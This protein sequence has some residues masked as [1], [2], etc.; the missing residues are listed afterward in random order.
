MTT[1]NKTALSA[2]I[3]ANKY[4]TLRETYE[5]TAKLLAGENIAVVFCRNLP[6]PALF[7][8]EKRI[9]KINYLAD[10]QIHLT[11]GLVAHEVG[12]ALFTNPTKEDMKQL[13]KRGFS[14]L[15]N[16]VEDGYQ[17]RKMCKAFPGSRKHLKTVFNHFFDDDPKA[18]KPSGK[19]IIDI[20]NVLNW[21]CKGVKHGSIKQ[22]PDYVI[23]DDVMLLFEAENLNLPTFLERWEFIKRLSEALKK[24]ALNDDELDS[25]SNGMGMEGQDL[26]ENEHDF[27]SDA[28]GNMVNEQGNLID[29][30]GNEIKDEDG[31]PQKGTF[32]DANGDR[33]DLDG[34]LA[35]D[36]GN[37]ILDQNGEPQSG[38]FK[39]DEGNLVNKDGNRINDDGSLMLDEDGDTIPGNFDQSQQVGSGPGNGQGLRPGKIPGGSKPGT[40]GK[41]DKGKGKKGKGKGQPEKFEEGTNEASGNTLEDS[42]GLSA[43]EL[44]EK[45]LSENREL[46]NDHHDKFKFSKG[47]DTYML[48]DAAC[49]DEIS[50]HLYIHGKNGNAYTELKRYRTGATQALYNDHMK[51]SKRIAQQLYSRFNVMKTT[52]NVAKTQYKKSGAID[53]TRLSQYKWNDDIFMNHELAPNVTNHGIVAVLDW[54]GSMRGSCMPLI[55]RIMEL[56]FF[57]QLANIT[58]EVMLYTTGSVKTANAALKS[59]PAIYDKVFVG[60]KFMHILNSAQ[61]DFHV[62]TGLELLWNLA[63]INEDLIKIQAPAS[64]RGMGMDGTNILESIIVGH[65]KL[66]KMNVDNKTLFVLTDGDDSGDFSGAISSMTNQHQHV[67]GWHNNSDYDIILNGHSVFDLYEKYYSK[68]S[69]RNKRVACTRV[70]CD[71]FKSTKGHK[72][73]GICWMSSSSTLEQSIGS[74]PITVSTHN[75][76]LKKTDYVEMDNVFIKEV[77]DSLL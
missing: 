77:I 6:A 29:K 54:S 69:A 67:G 16:A 28:D 55:Q 48:A 52:F 33:V 34:D 32:R 73:R 2:G 15:F 7:E 18:G 65:D 31:N 20:V 36:K 10:D 72:T 56:A 46:L 63:A 30:D 1:H 11:T 38:Q 66:D 17:E 45:I 68:S 59:K 25:K 64:M 75:K 40:T 5:L 62:N 60:S 12:H 8:M 35:D 24:Y 70:L 27:Y 74:K 41:A 23:P 50:E 14:H 39:D 43:D 44:I 37:K 76:Q 58:F 61:G 19:K 53:P 9:L 49:L 13:K 51:K 42:S 26:L 21:N 57:C 71:Y 22:Y 4:A 3:L 47:K